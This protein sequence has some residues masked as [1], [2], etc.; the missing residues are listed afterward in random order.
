MPYVL[1]IEP[2]PLPPPLVLDAPA[3]LVADMIDDLPPYEQQSTDVQGFLTAVG[4]E[5]AR[6]E[7]GRQE[8][9]LNYFP[10][11]ADT[12][13]GLFEQTLGIPV[14][15]PSLTLAQRQQA[16]LAYMQGLKQGGSGLEWEAAITRVAGTGWTYME[17]TPSAYEVEILLPFTSPA[18]VPAGLATTPSTSSGTLP[19]HT[20]FYAVTAVTAYGETL[21]C[22][23]VTAVLSGTGRVLLSWTA[24]GAPATGYNVYRAVSGGSGFFLL[25]TVTASNYTDNGSAT[26][27]TTPPPISDSSGSPRSH[28]ILLLARRYTPAHLALI[29]SYKSGFILDVSL[30]G[31]DTL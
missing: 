29:V 7:Q 26:I 2:P 23:A 11:T 3:A 12:L 31:S 9:I 19:A 24:E 28:T 21:P 4:N 1:D 27:T 16:V 22:A 15:P 13:L 6:V 25:T 5:L 20:Y 14:E 30:L 8:V 18:T 17:N 10:A